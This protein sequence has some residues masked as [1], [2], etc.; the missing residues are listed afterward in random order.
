MLTPQ[1]NDWWYG[2]Y[3]KTG[4]TVWFEGKIK[5]CIKCH[6]IAKKTDYLFTES[7]ME[8]IDFQE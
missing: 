7:V 6:Q 5:S 8:E 3:D 1:N 4:T 2:A